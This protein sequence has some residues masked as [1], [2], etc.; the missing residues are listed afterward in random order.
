MPIS[1]D[2]P[3]PFGPSRPTMS[4]ASSGERDVRHGAAPAEVPRDV[5]QL[6]AIETRSLTRR[7]LQRSPGSGRGVVASSSA[8]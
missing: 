2:L 4:P 3:A 6:D 5:G 7:R 8:P 1:V